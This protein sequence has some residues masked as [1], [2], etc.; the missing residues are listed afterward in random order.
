MNNNKKNRLIQKY[1]DLCNSFPTIRISQIEFYSKRK[2]MYNVHKR[3]TNIETLVNQNTNF[4]YS[5]HLYGTFFKEPDGTYIPAQDLD[6]II[7]NYT[8]MQMSDESIYL[9]VIDDVS[10]DIKGNLI[11]DVSC[12]ENVPQNSK[13]S[14]LTYYPNSSLVFVNH[15]GYMMPKRA[16]DLLAGHKLL[17]FDMNYDISDVFIDNINEYGTHIKSLNIKTNM[18]QS[19]IYVPSGYY[20]ALSPFIKIINNDTY[21]PES[22]MFNSQKKYVIDDVSISFKHIIHNYT[23]HIETWNTHPNEYDNRLKFQIKPISVFGCLAGQQ[24]YIGHIQE[25]FSMCGVSELNV[26]LSSP[27][28]HFPSQTGYLYGLF[29]SIFTNFPDK[30]VS[31]MSKNKKFINYT[32]LSYPET[33]I[34]N[35]SKLIPFNY[36]RENDILTNDNYIN[37]IK[38]DFVTIVTIFAGTKTEFMVEGVNNIIVPPQQRKKT[39]DALS[40]KNHVNSTFIKQYMQYDCKTKNNNTFI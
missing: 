21:S 18:S 13:P 14:M 28:I 17:L 20:I 3:S 2:E 6:Y 7:G 39:S 34:P 15:G 1:V 37:S 11:L 38:V 32:A 30:S 27:L 36:I 35:L 22:I 10:S 5:I 19:N 8:A 29:G 4:K 31:A 33:I 24:Y 40:E 25:L 26:L 23:N 9:C 16:M 12:N